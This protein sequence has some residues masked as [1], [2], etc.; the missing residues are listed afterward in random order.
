M[1]YF[2]CPLIELLALDRQLRVTPAPMRNW[3]DIVLVILGLLEITCGAQSSLCCRGGWNL[4]VRSFQVSI[5]VQLA[6]LT[7][8]CCADRFLLFCIWHF[9]LH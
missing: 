3:F 9:H 2:R 6:V 1:A 4:R 5:D 7:E 8:G